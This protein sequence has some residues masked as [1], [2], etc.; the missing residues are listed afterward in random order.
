MSVHLKR[1]HGGQQ[2]YHELLL[3]E[4]SQLESE[5]T[6]Q[7]KVANSEHD[8]NLFMVN[9]VVMGCAVPWLKDSLIL[10]HPVLIILDSSMEP[11]TFEAFSNLLH[12]GK[13]SNVDAKTLQELRDL[14][15]ML[16]LD[17][18]LHEEAS[19]DDD[20]ASLDFNGTCID[21][22]PDHHPNESRMKRIFTANLSEQDLTCQMC[23]RKFSALYKLKIHALIHSA[24]PPFVCSFCGRGFNNKYKMRGHEKRHCSS[25]SSASSNI[26]KRSWP[27]SVL[28]KRITCEKCGAVFDT[29]KARREHIL[30]AHPLYHAS[31]HSC[32]LCQKV[33][34]ALKGLNSHIANARCMKPKKS[35]QQASSDLKSFH[36]DK[37]PTVCSSRKSLKIH[38][39]TAHLEEG[40]DALPYRCMSCGK[41]FLKQSYL[42]EHQ[43]RFHTLIKPFP[44]MFCPKRCATKQDLD[45]HLMS[46]RGETIFQCSFCPKSFVHRASLKKHHRGHLRER[47][48]Q[49]HP[50]GKSYGL[51]TVLQK[52]QKSHERKV[53]YE[54]YGL[55]ALN[56]V[57]FL[58]Y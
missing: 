28:D 4:A 49:C 17:F 43:N 58:Y 15:Q 5:K 35:H 29:K 26:L 50:C 37:C 33:F 12:C 55:M 16:R 31:T 48:Y 47:P 46:H 14:G 20:E 1:G 11:G 30:A 40:E 19:D 53:N 18:E 13:A 25:S 10:D 32:P 2:L 7:I 23:Q 27:D 6:V 3:S 41:T 39:R 38:G 21:E 22:D 9:S 54:K 52:H 42:E 56:F 44:C 57:A 51:L 24:T 45:R 8:G 34:K 36:C